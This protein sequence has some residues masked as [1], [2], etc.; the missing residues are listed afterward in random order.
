MSQIQIIG[1]QTY[2]PSEVLLDDVVGH[3]VDLDLLVALQRFDLVDAAALLDHVRHLLRVLARH[4]QHVAQ[5][6][7]HHLANER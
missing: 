7:E 6:V 1:A 3:L 5:T 4:L 2:L